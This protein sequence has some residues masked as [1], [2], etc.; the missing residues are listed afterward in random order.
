MFDVKKQFFLTQTLQGFA[1]HS[2]NLQTLGGLVDSNLKVFPARLISRAKHL[3]FEAEV[4]VLLFNPN[5]P[6]FSLPT[7]SAPQTPEGF[8]TLP[9]HSRVFALAQNQLL[10]HLKVLPEIIFQTF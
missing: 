6:G 10:K 1:D 7:K 4:D 8:I 5:T 3:A 2:P 9:K